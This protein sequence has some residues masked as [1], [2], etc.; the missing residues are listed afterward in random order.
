MLSL[1][2]KCEKYGVSASWKQ[3]Q[4]KESLG[5]TRCFRIVCR[6]LVSLR[7]TSHTIYCSMVSSP[8]LHHP[9]LILIC[10]PPIV[11]ISIF[12]QFLSTGGFIHRSH[13]CFTVVPVTYHYGSHASTFYYYCIWIRLVIEVKSREWP[14]MRCSYR[15]KSV[16]IRRNYASAVHS[17]LLINYL[18][19][20]TIIWRDYSMS[21]EL[22]F[23]ICDAHVNVFNLR[24]DLKFCLVNVTRTFVWFFFFFA[25]VM[26]FLNRST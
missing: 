11:L 20:H 4:L 5:W 23:P 12:R 24:S 3:I 21:Y 17:V 22:Y 9:H 2:F 14:Y 13:E 7:I 18:L 8:I 16:C 10:I 1:L 26:N 6:R 15:T 19:L 25:Q